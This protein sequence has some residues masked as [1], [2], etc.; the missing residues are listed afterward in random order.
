MAYRVRGRSKL[1]KKL[2]RLPD[3][4]KKE[5]QDVIAEEADG[6][7]QEAQNN[8]PVDRGDLKEVM[9]VYQKGDKLSARIGFWK[10][11]NLRKW[12]KAGWR[13][14][15]VEFGTRLQKAKPFLGP[16]FR[17]RAPRIMKRIDKAVD[18]T[19]RKATSGNR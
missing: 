8:I 3:D 1:R 5:L 4:M 9:R 11:G 16:I 2:S 15:F 13:A 12:R 17:R 7:Y 14:H 19:L 18:D 6:I 10:K